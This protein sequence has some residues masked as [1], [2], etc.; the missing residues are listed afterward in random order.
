M[1][2]DDAALGFDTLAI[3]AGQQPNAATGAVVVPIYQ[4]STYAQDEV[5]VTRGGYEYSRSAN[6]TRTALETC[7]AALERGSVGLAFASGMAAEDTL[8]RTVCTPG[9]QVVLPS[10]AYGGTFRL[11]TSV[12]NRWGVDGR[13]ASDTSADAV[14][15][16]CT[17]HTRVVWCETPTNPLLGIADIAALAAVAH[18]AGALLV[19]DNTFAS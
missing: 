10:D 2:D 14:R 1:T 13:I 16:A 19:V 15:K 4:T 6:P 11:V 3:H 18:D 5:G 9:D 8:L 12:F 7:L 17:E